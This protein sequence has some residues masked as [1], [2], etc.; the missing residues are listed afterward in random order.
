MLQEEENYKKL[1]KELKGLTSHIKINNEMQALMIKGDY[2]DNEQL[3]KL[4]EYLQKL[5]TSL[6]A[7]KDEAKGKKQGPS[8]ALLE[9]R[10]LQYMNA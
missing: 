1:Y 10:Y 7:G 2:N 3:P 6:T 8:A 4:I 9:L 5:K